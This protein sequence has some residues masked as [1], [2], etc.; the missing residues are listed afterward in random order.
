MLNGKLLEAVLIVP[1]TQCVRQKVCIS[2]CLFLQVQLISME[3]NMALP[4]QNLTVPQRLLC[5]RRGCSVW[6][7]LKIKRF[8]VSP[9]N[10]NPV[11]SSHELY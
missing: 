9:L 8:L 2:G 4:S 6:Q 11:G 5:S 7:F 1:S 10:N 3:M